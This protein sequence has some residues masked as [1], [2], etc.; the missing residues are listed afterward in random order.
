MTSSAYEHKKTID[1]FYSTSSPQ[2][3][4]GKKKGNRITKQF[5][6]KKENKTYHM[7]WNMM[8]YVQFVVADDFVD[9]HITAALSCGNW[10]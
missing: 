4:R 9:N 10:A 8:I 5:T 2:D 7:L 1:F 6:E 3:D